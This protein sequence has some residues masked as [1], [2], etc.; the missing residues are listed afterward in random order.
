[1]S[2]SPSWVDILKYV[3]KVYFLALTFLWAVRTFFI[4]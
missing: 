3:G 2:D 4:E 1:M